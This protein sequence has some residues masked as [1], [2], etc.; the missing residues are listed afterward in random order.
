MKLRPL[1]AFITY[2]MIK[3]NIKTREV[4]TWHTKL[5]V[6]HLKID[7]HPLFSEHRKNLG[8]YTFNRLAYCT[9]KNRSL[10]IMSM[11]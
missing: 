10:K 8:Q 2:K 1:K 5:K 6:I 9:S 7:L 4:E 11:L 3:H